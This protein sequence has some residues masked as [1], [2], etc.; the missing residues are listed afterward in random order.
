MYVKPVSDRVSPQGELSYVLWTGDTAP[1]DSW[2]T[3]RQ[4]VLSVTAN[5]TALLRHRLA[6][7]PVYPVIG[8]HDTAPTN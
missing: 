7:V 1:H 2:K 4:D 5:V 8:N 6:G 3:S